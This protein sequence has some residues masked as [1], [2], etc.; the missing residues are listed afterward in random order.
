[1]LGL[2]ENQYK[3]NFPQILRTHNKRYI[4]GY[5][6]NVNCNNFLTKTLM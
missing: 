2:L 5:F 6:T 3:P 4:L 1:M